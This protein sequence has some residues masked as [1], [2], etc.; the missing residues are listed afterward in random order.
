[1]DDLLKD[2]DDED[3][4]NLP[5]PGVPI[6][7]PGGV[8]TKAEPSGDGPE[9]EKKDDEVV[10]PSAH[11]LN[12][13]GIEVKENGEGKT[14]LNDFLTFEE[15]VGKGQFCSVYKANGY[16]KDTDETIP[17]AMKAFKTMNLKRTC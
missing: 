8:A 17:Y 2:F 6:P 15:K 12:Y 3:F 14:V 10:D 13:E 11:S 5:V 4:L 9:E 7:V 16:Y 1:M